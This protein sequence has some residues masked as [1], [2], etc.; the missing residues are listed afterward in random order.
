MSEQEKQESQKTVV[1]FAA[2]LLI[3]GL[4]VWIFGGTPAKDKHDE[5]MKKDDTQGEEIT[6]EQKS[7]EEQKV[8]MEK[9]PEMM[10]GEG[11]A[12]VKAQSAG[13]MVKLESTTFPSDEG[14]IGVRDYA[15]G[16]TGYIL[17]VARF[18]KSQG[19]VPSE[20]SLVRSTVAGK[21]YAV[22]YFKEDGDKKF[23]AAKDTQLEG[24]VSTF[25]AE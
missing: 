4:L 16:K 2:G 18:S 12:E 25:K 23:N 10:V 6:L 8:E 3:G 5:E 14:W 19:L 11:K 1:A 13:K 9:A 15:D 20:V 7:D 21:E 22:V 24:V 17:G